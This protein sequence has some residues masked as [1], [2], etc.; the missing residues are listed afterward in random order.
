MAS[1]FTWRGEEF[2]NLVRSGLTKNLTA[3]GTLLMRD[4]KTALNKSGRTVTFTKTKT[5]KVRKKLGK[6]GSDPSKPGEPP[7]K[8]TGALR[9]KVFKKLRQGGKVIRVG[10]RAPH[11]GLLEFGTKNMAPRPYLRSTLAEDE[12]EIARILTRPIQSK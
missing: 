10:T 4:V 5:G 7:R 8:Q 9:N 6:R 12:G 1:D 3:A 11:G 2:K